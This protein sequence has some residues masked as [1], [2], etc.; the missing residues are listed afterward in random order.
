MWDREIFGVVS[1]QRCL[2]LEHR[3]CCWRH[4]ETLLA[5][6]ELASGERQPAARS[7]EA[8]VARSVQRVARPA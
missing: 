1:L 6:G 8:S 7:L 3:E 2:N 4:D 5:E